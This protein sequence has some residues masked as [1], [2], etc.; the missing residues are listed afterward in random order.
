M[1]ST[2]EAPDRDAG[3]FTGEILG[4]A[5]TEEALHAAATLQLLAE[6]EAVEGAARP[7]PGQSVGRLGGT[8]GP[9]SMG[10]GGTKNVIVAWFEAGTRQGHT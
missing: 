1:S 7:A 3:T 2:D 10:V 8:V 6:V 4:G 5:T 9:Q